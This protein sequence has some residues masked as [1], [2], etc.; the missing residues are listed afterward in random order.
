MLSSPLLVSL[1]RQVLLM[2]SPSPAGNT[3]HPTSITLVSRL[4]PVQ[5]LLV[6]TGALLTSSQLSLMLA[7]SFTET[8]LDMHCWGENPVVTA[9]LQLN[10]QTASQSVRAHTS[11]LFSPTSTTP[12]HLTL[13]SMYTPSPSGPRST[14][15]QAPAISHALTMPHF[16]LFFPMLPLAVPTLPRSAYATNYNVS[17]LCLVWVSRLL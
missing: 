3:L 12:A 17:E 1:I 11:T 7:H 6:L 4:V 15:H 2:Q 5:L 8:S 14:S 9:K 10:G 16:S 13:V